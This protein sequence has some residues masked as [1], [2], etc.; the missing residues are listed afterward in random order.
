MV[1]QIKHLL[2][3]LLLQRR[4]SPWFLYLCEIHISLYQIVR[5]NTNWKGEFISS[6]TGLKPS[7]LRR[8]L[9]NCIELGLMLQSTK[10]GMATRNGK[11]LTR[12]C[13]YSKPCLPQL[14]FFSHCTLTIPPYTGDRFQSYSLGFSI[15]SGYTNYIR[16]HQLHYSEYKGIIYSNPHSI[17]CF[18]SRAGLLDSDM[19]F[20]TEQHVYCFHSQ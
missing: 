9:P 12:C 13:Y 16:L 18:Y 11:S 6:R 8:S 3:L 15:Y 19:P 7:L 20:V 4:S 1:V 2:L 10:I 5:P 14:R 17:Q